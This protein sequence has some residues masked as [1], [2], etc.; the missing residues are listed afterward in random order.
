MSLRIDKERFF[1]NLFN[2]IINA[3]VNSLLAWWIYRD[4]HRGEYAFGIAL[5]FFWIL[6]CIDRVF[7]KLV[8]VGAR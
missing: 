7:D 6:M 2:F 8:E 5:A 4:L 1:T 3:L